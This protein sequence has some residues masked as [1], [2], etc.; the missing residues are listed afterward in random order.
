MMSKEGKRAKAADPSAQCLPLCGAAQEGSWEGAVGWWD[1]PADRGWGES[2]CPKN[3]K[4]NWGR[5]AF[6]TSEEG[7]ANNRD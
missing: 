3:G 4:Q 1:S 2:Y 5:T 7:F 6:S